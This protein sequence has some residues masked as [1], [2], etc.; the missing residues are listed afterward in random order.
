VGDRVINILSPDARPVLERIGRERALLAFDYDG[1][2][3]P[4]VPRPPAAQMRPNTRGL[5]TRIAD[6]YPTVVLSGRSR[7]DL[8]ER[9]RG[10]R[11]VSIIGNHG[12]EMDLPSAREAGW[13][14]AVI[15]WRPALADLPDRFPGVLVEDKGISLSVHYRLAKEAARARR[16]IVRVLGKL[17]GAR[18]IGGKQVFNVMP[19]AADTKGAAFERMVRLHRCTVGLYVGDDVTDEHVFRLRS[20]RTIGIRVGRGRGSAAAYYLDNQTKVDL[21]LERLLDLPA[22][23]RE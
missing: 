5:L 20:S 16:G 10:I 23:S 1:T 11:L 13:R 3:A 19:A 8:A 18:I 6:R 21:L 4:I 12:A 9:L 2:L 15:R 14:E 22:Q 17:R 7:A